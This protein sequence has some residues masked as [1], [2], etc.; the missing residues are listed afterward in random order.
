MNDSGQ[1]T[2][3][4]MP[5]TF[6]S[7]QLMNASDSALVVVD[8]QEKLVPHIQN[9]E[10]VTWNIGRLITGANLL[11]IKIVATEQYPKGLGPT[12]DSIRQPLS[13]CGTSIP[14]KTMFSCRECAETFS[15]LYQQ[16]IYKLLVTGIETHVCVA[17][18]VLDFIAAGFTVYVCVDA[19]GSR[20]P[21]DHATALRRLE[22]SGAIP[23][24]TESA[25]FEWC[26]KAGRDE[27]KTISK[28]V[29]EQLKFES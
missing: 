16:G 22:N 2:D 26:E 29:Q 25:L 28:L 20:Y 17:Q 18:T 21:V 7:P 6:R 23:T 8:M 3:S 14:E 5:E 24:T 10:K 12:V 19:V 27:F 13:D 1:N 9:H 15:D 4:T 11:G